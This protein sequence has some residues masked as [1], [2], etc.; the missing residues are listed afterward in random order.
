M[1][2]NWSGV[3]FPKLIILKTNSAE[4]ASGFYDIHQVKGVYFPSTREVELDD[5][6][7]HK[8]KDTFHLH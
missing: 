4:A 5:R 8:N 2:A 3:R 7:V 1:V 6:V